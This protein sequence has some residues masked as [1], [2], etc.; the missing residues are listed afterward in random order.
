MKTPSEQV[1]REML[2]GVMLGTE[3]TGKAIIAS[4]FSSH[5]ARLQSI[6]EFGKKLNRKIVFLGRSL[7]KYVTAGENIGI[8][9]FTQDVE[10]IRYRKQIKKK[11]NQI[12]KDPSKYLIVCTGHQGEEKS[13]L[14][15]IANKEFEF[16]FGKEDHIIFSCSVIPTAL[17][18]A[19]RELLE[20]NLRSYGVRIFKNIHVSGH[21]AKEDLRDLINMV[22]PEHI[23]PAHGDMTMSSSLAELCTEM[24]YRIGDD[25][26]IM[27][28]GQIIEFE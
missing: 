13:V 28:N 11:L 21:A 7:G 25:V 4:T 22:K 18:K 23:I 19:N 10:L 17:N 3:S 14:S 2:K 26:H 6:I 15:R 12:S 16:R 24:G 20:S 8:I 5:L 27:R 1:A 9:N